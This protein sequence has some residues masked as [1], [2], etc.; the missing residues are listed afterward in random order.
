M[1]FYDGE[2]VDEQSH[3]EPIVDAANGN[4][5]LDSIPTVDSVSHQSTSTDGRSTRP[6]RT[7]DYA[8]DNYDSM[9]QYLLY[10][11][12]GESPVCSTASGVC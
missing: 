8:E 1:D 4:M 3:A 6:K 12:F 10:G 2:T 5:P 7:I 9:N 11:S